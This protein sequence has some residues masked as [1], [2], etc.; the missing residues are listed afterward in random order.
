MECIKASGTEVC[1]QAF[2]RRMKEA[3]HADLTRCYQCY[4]C[5]SSCPVAYAMDYY[6]HQMIRMAQL[7]LKKPLLSCSA[8][9]IC[10][11]CGTC[12]ARCPNEVDVL[13]V[14]DTLRE[15]ALQE[16]VK[17]KE[18]AIVTMHKTFLSLIAALGR[19]HEASLILLLKIKTGEF[20]KD[21]PL[22][23]KMFLRGKLG[24]FPRRIK[25]VRELKALFARSGRA[26]GRG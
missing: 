25:S 1:D 16:G 2:A 3:S 20:L 7:G 12:V 14:I 21:V 6:P 15:T 8:I 19:Q 22:G 24:I 4:V 26:A 5:T 10:A 11:A 17:T 13:K 18:R 9:W 23:I